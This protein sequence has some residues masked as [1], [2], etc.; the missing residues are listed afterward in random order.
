MEAYT[1]E[2]VTGDMKVVNWNQYATKWSHLKDIEFPVI[3]SKVEQSLKYENERYQVAIPWKR[4]EP[5]VS[6]NYG[7]AFR[8]LQ[9][10]E[11]RLKRNM[12]LAGV[13]SDIIERYIQKEYIRKVEETEKRPLEAWYLPHF[14]AL[15]PDRPT[16]K[17]RIVFDASAKDDGVS[18]NDEIY[19]GPKL[20]RDLFNILIR[21][22][23]HPVALICDIAE[24]YLR[25]EVAPQDRK[26]QRFLWRS[27]DEDKIPDEYEFNGVVFGINSSPFQAQYVVQQHAKTLENI[28][29]MAADTV[30]ES[31]YMDDSMDSVATDAQGIELYR[32]LSEMYEKADMYPHKWLSNSVA[33][34]EHIPEEK[35]A[36]NVC[37]DKPSD[38]PTVKTL[39]LQWLADEDSFTFNG[40]S[41]NNDLP[42]TKR[43]FLKKMASLFDP[44]GGFLHHLSSKRRLF[45]KRYG[46]EDLIGMMKSMIT[47]Y[48]RKQRRGSSN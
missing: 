6:N 5:T 4:S 22:R 41:Y 40:Q 29:P 36:T 31:T 24:I 2:K 17:T 35:R 14:P 23:E 1:T 20:Q 46:R 43:N 25:I 11:K 42:P 15:R 48:F 12:E 28:Y 21:F 19:Q 3:A 38:F 9:N 30:N 39:G 7:M 32:Q 26:Y 33:M 16:T 18:L 45:F 34:L 27:M 47:T 8:R 13:Y 44:M 37:I 10:T